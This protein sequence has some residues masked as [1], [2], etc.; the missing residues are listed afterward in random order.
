MLHEDDGFRTI[1]IQYSLDHQ[2]CPVALALSSSEHLEDRYIGVSSC[3]W[4]PLALGY[5]RSVFRSRKEAL[6]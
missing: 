3:I 6:T 2:D 5:R 4:T 1:L